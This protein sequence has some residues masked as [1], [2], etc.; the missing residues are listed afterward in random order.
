[1]RNYHEL[2][3]PGHYYHVFNR[4]VGNERLFRYHGNYFFFLQQ[5][6]KYIF[7][8]AEVYCYCLLPNHFHF[9]IRIKPVEELRELRGFQSLPEYK[10]SYRL[11]KQFSN[12]FNSYARSYNN[13]FE[14]KGTLF[15]RA[16]KRLISTDNLYLTKLVYY[17]HAN[18]VQHGY[19]K[20]IPHWYYSSYRKIL[21]KSAGPLQRER[22]LDWFGGLR[23]FKMAHQQEI[24]VKTAY[25]QER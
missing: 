18:P 3:I 7:P 5:F 12:L 17:I 25:S 10:I 21:Y 9:L 19:C 1:M 8:I 15:T 24:M 13:M 11:S 2:M 16:F 22:V 14:R 23:S 4:A 20:S 6:E